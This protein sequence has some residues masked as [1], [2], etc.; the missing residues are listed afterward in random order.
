MSAQADRMGTRLA[1]KVAI[2]TGVA[3][4]IGAATCRL[5][6]REGTTGVLIAD[7]DEPAGRHSSIG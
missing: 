5:F 6:A 7:L 3:S 4:G 1:G 2:L